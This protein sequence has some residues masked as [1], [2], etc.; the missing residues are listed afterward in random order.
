MDELTKILNKAGFE[1]VEGI[2]AVRSAILQEAGEDQAPLCSGFRVFPGGKKCE[3]CS[4]CNG[5]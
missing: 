2:D 4:D 5:R 1:T 3:G